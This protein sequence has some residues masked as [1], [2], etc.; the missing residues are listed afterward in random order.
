MRNVFAAGV[1]AALSAGPDPEFGHNH[2]LM[3]AASE[4]LKKMNCYINARP[5][6]SLLMGTLHCCSLPHG[7]ESVGAHAPNSIFTL[8]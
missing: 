3:A 2:W 7:P 1:Q 5:V 4:L 6:E 8:D